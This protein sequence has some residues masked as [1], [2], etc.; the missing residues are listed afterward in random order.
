MDKH[1]SLLQKIIN[2]SRKRLYSIGLTKF[3]FLGQS[4]V[5]Y[6]PSIGLGNKKSLTETQNKLERLS[7]QLFYGQAW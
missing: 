6:R 7:L 1:S 2:Y 5:F 3:A 4:F